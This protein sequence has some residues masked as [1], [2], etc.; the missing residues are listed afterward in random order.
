M[1]TKSIRAFLAAPLVLAGLSSVGFSTSAQ[2]GLVV[3]SHNCVI[4]NGLC[5][6]L[7]AHGAPDGSISG[8]PAPVISQPEPKIED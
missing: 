6:K 3:A 1:K 7:G 8:N 4:A 5:V 2:A